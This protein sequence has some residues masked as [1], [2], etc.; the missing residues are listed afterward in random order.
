MQFLTPMIQS[1]FAESVESWVRR[2]WQARF[3][4]REAIVVTALLAIIFECA[5]LGA[6]FVRGELLL[7]TSDSA[8]ILGTI[9]WVIGIKLVLFYWRG[10]CHRPWR[11]ARFEDLNR[12]L[13]TTTTALLVLVA[14]NYFAVVLGWQA[15][16]RSVLLLD[17]VFTLLGVGG[18]QAFA[19]SIYE[20]IMP[21]THVG[22]RNSALVIDASK[23]GREL[24]AALP[25]I[26]QQHYFVAGLL[27]DDPEHYGVS[28]GAAR[29]L[30]PVA[31][32]PTCAERLR[33]SNLIVR[34]GAVFGDRLRALCDASQT[35]GVRVQI[36]EGCSASPAGESGRTKGLTGSPI[37]LRDVELADLLAR[38]HARLEEDDY[39]VGALLADRRVLVTGAAG[40]VG[41]EICR[42]VL[43][44]HPS[45]LVLV[46][47]SEAGLFELYRVLSADPAATG[48]EITARLCDVSEASK[49]SALIEESAPDVILHAAAFKHLPLMESHPIEAIENNT[50]ATATLAD[51][52]IKHGVGTFIMLSTDKAVYPS[53]VM[54]ASKLVAERYVA[55]LAES[56]G[57]KFVA[58]RFGNVLGSSGS[59]VP[60]FTDR[61][62]RR[63]PIIVTDPAVRR[64]FVT[65]DEAAQLVLLAGAISQRGGVYLLEMGE[66]VSIVDLVGSI[67]FVMGLPKDEVEITFCGLRPGEK[68]DEDV[69]FDDE[70]L[71]PTASPLIHR[72]SGP[73]WTIDEGRAALEALRQAVGRG[74]AAAAAALEEVAAVAAGGNRSRSNRD[75]RPRP[76]MAV[77]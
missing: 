15:I 70:E 62:S 34:E 49:I 26:S 32:A 47:W 76:N 36:A 66:A 40:S 7:K 1:R 51:L 77:T 5:Y 17:W 48:V 59:A 11:A 14:M 33:V 60:I 22:N 43:R 35:I 9:G 50:L 69:I 18:M 72:A 63:E 4:T 8:A 12:L 10:F 23:A 57:T 75:V 30:G 65:I 21:V 28:I 20:E 6:Y 24:A 45:T 74:P 71:E 13:R 44:F 52:A 27:D 3:P 38:P 31:M 68:L 29:V 61:L 67:A 41:A 42:Q 39:H 16:P 54:G 2:A 56:S 25:G 55:A 73:V 19:R 58:V 46:D 64:C 37:R 53:S